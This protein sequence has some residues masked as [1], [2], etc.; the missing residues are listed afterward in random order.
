[1]GTNPFPIGSSAREWLSW[2]GPRMECT[3][4]SDVPSLS[5]PLLPEQRRR[6]RRLAIASHA[7]GQ[8][9]SVGVNGDLTALALLALGAGEALVGGQRFLLYAVVLL[10]LPTLRWVGHT[11]K[12][13]ILLVGQI[14]ALIASLPLLGFSALGGLGEVGLWLAVACFTLAAAGFTVNAT[15]WFP[16]LHGYLLPSE[17]G[18]FFGILRSSWHLT[19]IPFFLGARAWLEARPGDFGPLFA[20]AVLCGIARLFLIARLP[21]RSERTGQPLELRHAFV[22]LWERENW[23]SYFAGVTI[24]SASRSVF[25]T[26]AVVMMRRDLGFSEGQI[27]Y[28]T[29]AAFTGGLVSLYISGTLVDRLGPVPLFRWTALGQ[30]LAVGSFVALAAAGAM[31]VA[32]AVGVFFVVALLASGFDLAD[33]RVL[34]ALAPGDAPARLL[35]PTTILRAVLSGVLPLAAGFGLEGAI[36]AGIDRI[37]AYCGLFVGLGVAIAVG[38]LPLVRFREFERADT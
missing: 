13:R 31:T 19:L 17:T 7:I 1:M 8:I 25:L 34:F 9:H 26:F 10:Q 29:A 14:A 2:E 21:E 30:A 28:A 16:M 3:A 33:T 37:S 4:F 27:L 20:F 23:R 15:V 11:S 5:A 35:V 24:S 22:D 36:E 38:Y 12:R 32:S 6:G 18:R